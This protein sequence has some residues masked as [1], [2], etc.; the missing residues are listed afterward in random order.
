MCNDEEFT[1]TLLSEYETYL[2]RYCS[3][4]ELTQISLI[5]ITLRDLPLP[6]I[7]PLPI[8]WFAPNLTNPPPGLYV[9]CQNKTAFN[10]AEGRLLFLPT[11]NTVIYSETHPLVY[12]CHVKIKLH[13]M[14]QREGFYF[15]PPSILLFIPKPTPC[16]KLGCKSLSL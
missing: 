4:V 14:V 13:L 9:P 7:H 2:N 16:C 12:M 5:Y 6:P 1:D 11:L 10:G 3:Q 15:C 8:P